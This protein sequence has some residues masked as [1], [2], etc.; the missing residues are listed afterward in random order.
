MLLYLRPPGSVY[1]DLGQTQYVSHKGLFVL[2]AYIGEVHWRQSGFFL[3]QCRGLWH[4]HNMVL[5]RQNPRW[6]KLHD[7]EMRPL[8]RRSYG[9][10]SWL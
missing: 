3:L 1:T 5:H 6:V 8:G 9:R 4:C 7:T 2:A 10:Q